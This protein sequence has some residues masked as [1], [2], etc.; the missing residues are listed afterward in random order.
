VK[1]IVKKANEIGVAWGQTTEDK[2]WLTPKEV[3][4][5]L[6]SMRFEGKRKTD[7]WQYFTTLAR[8]EALRKKYGLEVLDVTEEKPAAAG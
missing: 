4:S 2:P 8:L 7:G 1:A 5:K 6:R 3:G